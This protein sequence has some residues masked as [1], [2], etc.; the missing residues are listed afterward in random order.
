MKSKFNLF[1]IILIILVFI[2]NYTITN[3]QDSEPIGVKV[4]NSLITTIPNN[5]NPSTLLNFNTVLI[6]TGGFY[7]PSVPNQL[8]IP[9]TGWYIVAG[10]FMY[11]PNS[12]GVREI[13]FK[14]NGLTITVTLINAVGGGFRTRMTL[15][16]VHHFTIGDIVTMGTYQNSGGN[17]SIESSGIQSPYF[18]IVKIP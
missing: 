2:S 6:D 1:V 12:I 17:L 5:T 18:S 9:E 16:T 4:T 14:V 8:T 11:F 10:G 3:A 15:S 13:F 7:N